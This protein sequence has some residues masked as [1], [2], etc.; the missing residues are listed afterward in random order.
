MPGVDAT[1]CFMMG[2]TFCHGTLPG[3]RLPRKILLNDLGRLS[4]RCPTL[5]GRC[6]NGL[7]SAS[8][9]NIATFGAAF[10]RSNFVLCIP[11]NIIISGP[12][13][14]IGV[15]HTSIGFVIGHHILII[16]RRDTRTHLLVYSRTV[17]GMGF[18]SA[19][20]VRIFTG[21]GTA[22]SLCR[23]RRARADAIH[24]DG[25]CIGRRT[26]DGILLGNVA[27]RGNAAH[28][29]ARM[30][31]TKHKTRVG[32]YNVIVTSGGRRI[33]GRAFVSRGITS[34]ADGRLFGCMLSSRT[35]NTFTKG[36]LMHRKTR[37]AGSRRAGHGLYTAH[38]TRVCARPRLRVCTSSMGYSRKTAINRLSRGTLFCVR[39]HNVDLGRTH[40][41]LVFT[42]IGRMVSAVH[43]STLGSHLRLLIRGHFH[44]RLGGYRKYTVY[45]WSTV[46]SVRGVERSFPV[47]SQRI[48]K[49]PLVCLS[50][51]T[52]ARGPHRIIRTVA[53][54]CCS[55]G[56]GIRHNIRFLSR[57]TARLRRTSHRAMHHFV[58]THDDGRVIFAQ[59]AARDVG[60]LTS[61]FTSDRV[62]RNSRIV[63]SI[64]RRRDGVMP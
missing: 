33:S 32:L 23:L 18:L 43:L 42:F 61:S 59:N 55:I 26:S 53:S 21:R 13:R 45:G 62:G 39:R 5:I 19:R 11:G 31:L 24:F 25:L 60:L 29:A 22:F 40:L 46:C 47:L 57:R 6:C 1:L 4:R 37:R 20:I 15:L 3:T 54:R 36:M 16:L 14:L 38:S 44:N 35:A 34:Y 48:C 9:S 56:T 12:V 8:G 7:T 30:A 64:V 17:S 41:L 58:G 28:G 50:G 27:L 51:K 49:G 10:T 63:I 52:A 2:S